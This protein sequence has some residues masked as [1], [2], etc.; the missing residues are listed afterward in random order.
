VVISVLILLPSCDVKSP[1]APSWD[2][3]LNLPLIDSTYSV[4]DMVKRDTTMLSP[5]YTRDG[6][7]VYSTIKEVE[8][9]EVSDKLNVD[10]F[11]TNSSKEIGTITL[12]GDS[13][14]ASV[15]FDWTQQNLT[16]GTQVPILAE[17]NRPVNS[18]FSEITQ[19]QTA[20]FE[21]GAITIEIKN[22][23]TQHVTLTIDGIAIKN[24]ASPNEIIAQSTTQLVIPPNST[25]SFTNIPLN[26]GVIVKNQLKFET[27]VSMSGS[28]GNLV[29][30]PQNSFSVNA[31]FDDLQVT[32]ARAKIPAQ[33]P[34]V[35]DSSFFIEADS[36]KP[37]KIKV[38]KIDQGILNILMDNNLDVDASIKLEIP[39]LKNPAGTSYTLTRDVNRKIVNFKFVDNLSLSD[40][41]IISL[42]NIPTNEIIYK[43]TFTTKS[44][45]DFRDIKSSDYFEAKI[46]FSSLVIKEFDG[47]VKPTNLDVVRSAIA[48]D[49][50]DLETKF[51]FTQLNFNKPVLELRLKPSTGSI[52][53]FQISGRLEGQN[54]LGEKSFLFLNKNTM[55]DT[56]ITQTDSIITLNPDS[57]SNFFKRFTKLPDSII[58]Y[59]G[60][61]LNPKYQQVLVTN[62]S[63]VTGNTR[64]EFP[65]DIGI[66]G[67]Q[68]KDSIDVEF[69]S[70]QQSRIRDVNSLEMNLVLTNGLPVAVSFTG[71]LYDSLNTFLMYFPPKYSNQDTVITVPGGVTDANGNVTTKTIQTV[72]IRTEKA[73]SDKLA[74]AKYMRIQIKLN[75]SRNSNLPVKFKTKDDLRIKGFGGV[76]YRIKP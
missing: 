48:L 34:V 5:D 40:Y 10:G 56:I 71:R 25:R 38:A 58:V 31:K 53:N 45:T 33:N 18:N 74:R 6:L 7:L 73:E 52:L 54:S 51:S 1:T 44:S 61:I 13:V 63:F 20:I 66:S 64:L 26:S 12:Q 69:D 59:S 70:D 9:I 16:P 76:N 2:I 50:K 75:T 47:I 3:E 55:S 68:F 32:E 21:Q 28:N 72:T 8:N 60:G 67:G 41:S 23:F 57:V 65:L 30:V 22:N 36:P 49:A 24:I 37:T 35:I 27:T 14:E 11:L 17:S 43:V 15:G 4:L 29:T 62:T 42:N 39:N 46:D 19:F